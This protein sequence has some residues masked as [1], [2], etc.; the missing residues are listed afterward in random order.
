MKDINE[1]NLNEEEAAYYN[2]LKT[3]TLYCLYIP[4]TSDSAINSS[5]NTFQ[6]K[7]DKTNL[8]RAYYYKGAILYS[9]LK[10]IDQ[11]IVF[12]KKAE[13]LAEELK[14]LPLCSKIYSHLALINCKSENFNTALYYEKLALSYSYKTGDKT[15]TGIA[16]DRIGSI[17]NAKDMLDSSFYYMK[18]MIPYIKYLKKEDQPGYFTNIG[19]TF[20][21]NGEFKKAFFYIKKSLAIKPTS[22]A[23]FLYGSILIEQGHEA[24]AWALWSK[25]LN[26][27]DIALKA[28]VMQWM[29]GFKKEKGEYKEAT[30]LTDSINIFKDSLKSIQ[31]AEAVMHIQKKIELNENDHRA[32]IRT[33]IIVGT[34]VALVIAFVLFVIYHTRKISR[35]KNIMADNRRM[36]EKYT[37]E[38]EKMTKSNKTNER[39]I[40]RLKKKNRRDKRQKQRDTG[41]RTEAMERNHGRRKHGTMAQGRL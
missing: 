28:E 39:E 16:L 13:Y 8:A 11:A 3:Q 6:K 33:R 26:T 23:Y 34:A 35:A 29:A 4:A 40:N 1:I 15:M 37:A 27:D 10:D 22:H 7:G 25:A 19:A 31:K 18:K 12:T 32:Y 21:N 36:M 38:L 20:Y 30:L 14:D 2:L 17:F 5:I 24:E 41:T 9:D